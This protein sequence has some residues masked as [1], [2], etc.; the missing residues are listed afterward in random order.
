[1]LCKSGF[2]QCDAQRKTSGHFI[3]IVGYEDGKFIINDCNSYANSQ[4]LWDYDEF[5]DQ[6]NNLWAIK[7]G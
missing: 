2:L 3:A 1:M 5:Y 7:K 6:I 4:R